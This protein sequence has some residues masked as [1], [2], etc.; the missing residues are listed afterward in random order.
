[1][2]AFRVDAN[3][4]VATGHMYRCISIA[5]KC[6]LAGKECIF[7][8]AEDE[9]TD[10]LV[11]EQFQY[12]VLHIKW[13]DWDY[14]IEKVKENLQKYEIECLVVDSYRVT[15]RFFEEINKEI[16]IFYMDDLCTK[17]YKLDATLH[18][19][20]WEQERILEKLYENTDVKVYSGMQYMPLREAFEKEVCNTEKKYTLLITTGGSDTYHITLNLLKALMEDSYYQKEPVCAV[21]GKLNTDKEKIDELACQYPNITIM[22]NISNMDEVMRQ[23]RYA[24]TAGGTSVYELMASGVPFVCF[25]F[26]DDQKYFGE[27][28]EEHENALWAGD[29]RDGVECLVEN[30]VVLLNKMKDM[31][32][33]Q[34]QELI[35]KNRKLLDGKGASRIAEIIVDLCQEK[36]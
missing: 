10:L 33:K 9:Y 14:G 17:K 2:I 20:E 16:P 22:Q 32:Q 6:R 31:G 8:L 13:D 30:M 26:S 21:L 1:M 27:R 24:V 15:E 28:L 19:S 4:S 34:E 5:K 29:A 11:K 25:G 7:F 3:M 18:Y 35:C 23:S 12:C 36:R